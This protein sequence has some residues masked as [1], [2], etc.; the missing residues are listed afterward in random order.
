M[1]EFKV[2]KLAVKVFET[3]E[4]MGAAAAQDIAE[5]LDE[6]FEVKE[7]ARMLFASAPSQNE[8]LQALR[9]KSIS[10]DRVELFH[11]DEYIGL[12]P[13]A[14]QSFVY[15]LKMNLLNKIW[16]RAA[17]FMEFGIKDSDEEIADYGRRYDQKPMDIACIGVGENGHLAFNDPGSA[18]FN[19]PITIKRVVL[20]EKCRQQQVN[21]GCFNKVE[22]V[23]KYAV[24]LTIPAIMRGEK[25]FC[26][27]PGSRKRDAVYK[28]L[29]GN[30]S[31]VCPASILRKHD[32]CILYLDADSYKGM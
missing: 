12:P 25:L 7:Y 23:P 11:M 27:V 13:N 2:D 6:V 20:D 21:D 32:S 31:E 30:I 24:T 22:D 8:M 4:Q 29:T 18:D 28:M 17:N 15:Y 14:T 5:R 10:W 19:D 16:V 9:K 26:M 3:S 1:V